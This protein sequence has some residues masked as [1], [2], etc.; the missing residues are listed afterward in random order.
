LPPSP[1][2]DALRALAEQYLRE[3]EAWG[4]TQPAAKEKEHMMRR[5]LK[6]HVELAKLRRRPGDGAPGD[7]RGSA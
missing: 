5:V 2:V 3:A 6:L 7:D 1:E 4:A